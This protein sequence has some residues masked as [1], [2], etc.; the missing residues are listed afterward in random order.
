MK[1]IPPVH[2]VKGFGTGNIY[3][4]EDEELTVVDTGVPQD[5]RLLV[6]RIK[7]LGRSPVEVGHILL[8]HF[9]VDHAGS[10]SAFRRLAG[11]R[12][13]AHADDAPYID[14]SEKSASVHKKGVLGRAASLVPNTARKLTGVPPVKVDKTLEDGDRLDLLG[15]IQVIHTPGHTPGSCCYYWAVKGILFTGDTVINSYHFLTLPTV[16][17]SDDYGQAAESASRLADLM[18]EEG[19]WLIC[20]GHGPVVVNQPREKL[21]RFRGRIIKRRS[22]K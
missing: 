14:G 5:Y 3:I 12:V 7:S 15:G 17:F 9:H 4:I 11:A 18:E 10:A 22:D 16:G 13:Y 6:D 2:R 1:S 8:T 19:V 20:P 21:L